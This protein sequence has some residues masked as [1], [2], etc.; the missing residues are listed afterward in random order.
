MALQ[1]GAGERQTLTDG[2]EVRLAPGKEGRQRQQP[3]APDSRRRLGDGTP[4]GG[5]DESETGGG[6]ADRAGAEIEVNPSSANRSS[7]HRT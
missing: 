4:A 5:R 7:S 3:L 2:S 6:T 1:E